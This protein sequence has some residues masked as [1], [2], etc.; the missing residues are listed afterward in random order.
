MDPREEIA[1]AERI[2]K[3]HVLRSYENQYH[4]EAW[5]DLP[6][7]P[8][9]SEIMPNDDGSENKDFFEE[10]DAYKNDP[11]YNTEVPEN[12]TKGPWP[13]KEKYIAAHYQI[14][15]ED[16]IAH[17][18][19]SVKSFKRN[20]HMDDDNFTHVYT[21]VSPGNVSSSSQSAD[22]LVGAL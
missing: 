11:L 3:D 10:W 22:H 18:R 4:S 2:I 19:S 1:I 9:A 7:V 12:I 15:R 13:S 6:E 16:A 20:Q 5:R 8:D 14:L 17:L 21:H